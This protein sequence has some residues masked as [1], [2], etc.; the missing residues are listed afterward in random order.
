M[1]TNTTDVVEELLLGC[2]RDDTSWIFLSFAV[3]NMFL[4]IF[5][6]PLYHLVK[7][8]TVGTNGNVENAHRFVALLLA[9]DLGI[10]VD[11]MLQMSV[12]DSSL[13]D[14]LTMPAHLAI[15]ASIAIVLWVVHSKYGLMSLGL[16]AFAVA[17]GFYGP[18]QSF[19]W[20]FLHR[21]VDALS[22]YLRIASSLTAF[23]LIAV[24]AVGFLLALRNQIVYVVVTA[25]LIGFTTV[26]GIKYFREDQVACCG[27]DA[28]EAHCPFWLT[29]HYS[30][31]L[32]GAWVVGIAWGLYTHNRFTRYYKSI[33]TEPPSTEPPIR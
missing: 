16:L 9:L 5:S 33:A 2:I 14:T 25:L 6:P 13:R 32:Y 20:H 24:L 22:L 12:N 11:G 8:H 3:L 4:F 18:T 19:L 31:V 10:L 15:I 29:D 21:A 23:L 27:P 26:V 1:S 30:V 17:G 7:A 28:P